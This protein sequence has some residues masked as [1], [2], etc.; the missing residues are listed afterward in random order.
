MAE[1]DEKGLEKF[2][3]VRVEDTDLVKELETHHVK[4]TGKVESKWLTNIISWIHSSCF[5]LYHMEDPLLPNRT[6]DER[7]VLW[8]EPGE[9]LCGEGKEDHLC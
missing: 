9:N 3:T 1:G 8:K 6:G 4:Y 2:Q 7:D 5:F